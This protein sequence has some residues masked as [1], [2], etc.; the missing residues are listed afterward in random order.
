M[1]QH[2]NAALGQLALGHVGAGAD[3]AQV[4]TRFVEGGLAG[5][6][7]PALPAIGGHP[8]FD[9]LEGL[10]PLHVPLQMHH[11]GI[12]GWGDAAQEMHEIGA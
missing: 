12:V 8:Q 5:Q 4:I 2:G 3:I 9:I 7:P 10:P 1:R 6:A 11:Q